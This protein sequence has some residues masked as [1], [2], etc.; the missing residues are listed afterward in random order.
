MK[1]KPFS[2]RMAGRW[3]GLQVGLHGIGGHTSSSRRQESHESLVN[4][5]LSSC[6]ALT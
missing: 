2:L 1:V 4:L 5:R 6:S 3:S